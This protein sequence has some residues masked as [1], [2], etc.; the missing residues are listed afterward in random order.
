MSAHRRS[1]EPDAVP[2]GAAALSTKPHAAAGA[3]EVGLDRGTC[4]R[5]PGHSTEPA[6][7]TSKSKRHGHSD[8]D[9]SPTNRTKRWE[10]CHDRSGSCAKRTGIENWTLL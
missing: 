8:E 6:V 4:R 1:A 5:R 7:S 2:A 9:L 10:R 3:S